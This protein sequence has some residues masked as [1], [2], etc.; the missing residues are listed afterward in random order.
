MCYLYLSEIVSLM[1]V[2]RNLSETDIRCIKMGCQQYFDEIMHLKMPFNW[3]ME[4][5]L[6][7]GMAMCIGKLVYIDLISRPIS[8]ASSS[9]KPCIMGCNVGS[10]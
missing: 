7:E 5:I 2:L 6:L 3:Y 1:K 10:G 9:E 4:S 8:D